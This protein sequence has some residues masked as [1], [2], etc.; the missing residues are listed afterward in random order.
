MKGKVGVVEYKR[1]II[2]IQ[3]DYVNLSENWHN[4]KGET[5]RKSNKEEIQSDSQE[6][7]FIIECLSAAKP[8]SMSEED[9]RNLVLKSVSS[10]GVW[11]LS[12]TIQCDKDHE[13]RQPKNVTK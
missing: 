6:V 8:S 11:N 13:G 3:K 9:D 2:F 10:L 12:I 1:H 5:Q 4:Y 7:T